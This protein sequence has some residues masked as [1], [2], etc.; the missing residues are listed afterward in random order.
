MPVCQYAAGLVRSSSSRAYYQLFSIGR[1]IET[2][3]HGVLLAFLLGPFMP[4]SLNE[5]ERSTKEK[6]LPSCFSQ[7][8]QQKKYRKPV[9]GLIPVN[10]GIN[11]SSQT[12]SVTTLQ[13]RLVTTVQV[14]LSTTNTRNL[15]HTVF[16]FVRAST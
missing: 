15:G 7:L 8:V 11:H 10:E 16:V 3:S 6:A 9:Y 4:E 13:V 5:K 14:S 12:S 2:T 1:F